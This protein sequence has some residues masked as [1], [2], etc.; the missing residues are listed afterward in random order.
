MAAHQKH[1][2]SF[3][4]QFLQAEQ[5]GRTIVDIC[6][7]FNISRKTYY[8]WKNL[9]EKNN[10]V[11]NR[12]RGRKK[13][14]DPRIEKIVIDLIKLNPGWSVDKLYLFLMENNNN[15]Q[16]VSRHW[17]Q[18]L[19]Q[20]NKLS[21]LESR[22]KYS[23]MH[24]PQ[25]APAQ[26]VPAVE[27]IPAIEQ[28]AV[29][30]AGDASPPRIT[31]SLNLSFDTIPSFAASLFN[32]Q[33]VTWL[34][35]SDKL[36]LSGT[37]IVSI[38]NALLVSRIIGA[39]AA[40]EEISGKI[41]TF[42]SAIALFC[43][44]FFF[45]YS[46]KYYITIAA[47]IL[48]SRSD[49]KKS[50]SPGLVE[51]VTG[52]IPYIG[53]V[54][55]SLYKRVTRTELDPVSLHKEVQN[56]ELT[57]YP[58]F[59]VQIPLYNEKKVA[60]RVTAAAAAMDYPNFEVLVCDDSTDETTQLL[61]DKWNGH[62]KVKILHR[63]IRS[64]FKG[65][66]LDNALKYMDERTEY[67][68]IFDADFVPY[69]DTLQLFAKYFKVIG[70]HERNNTI[71]PSMA[72]ANQV[73]KDIQAAQ[74]QGKTVAVQGYQ[75]HVLNKSENWITRAVRSEFAGS[76]I[77][78]RSGGQ[79]FGL[80]KQIAGSVYA[81]N[82]KVLR[83]VGWGT[84][85]TEDFQLTLKLYQQGYKVAYTPYIQAPSECVS[86]LKRLIR[87]R[88]R[89]AEGHSFNIKKQLFA[90]LKSPGMTPKE[91]WEAI[92]LTPY[93]LQAFIFILGSI[94]WIIAETVLRVQLP[95]WT[96]A[97]GWS[98]VLT[99]LFS[100]PLMNTVGLFL[101]EGEERDYL[102]IFSFITLC[103]ILAPFIGF[104]AVKGFLEKEEGPWFRTPKSGHITDKVNR[105]KEGKRETIIKY[106][107]WIKPAIN[108]FNSIIPERASSAVSPYLAYETAGNDFNNPRQERNRSILKKRLTHLSIL[109][110]LS[111]TVLANIA[112]TT[113]P[114]SFAVA[115]TQYART[116]DAD[117]LTNTATAA[118]K[119]LSS[120]IGASTTSRTLD[121]TNTTFYILT[122]NMNKNWTNDTEINDSNTTGERR[123]V[124]ISTDSS[125]NTVAVW[126]DSRTTLTTV[127][128]RFDNTQ[129]A[130][131]TGRYAA[132]VIPLLD[133]R[134]LIAGGQTS[135]PTNLSSGEIFDPITG[136]FSAIATNMANARY[137]GNGTVLNDGRAFLVSG[138]SG[139]TA[140][141]TTSFF[142]PNTNSFSA[143]P[144]MTTARY[145]APIEKLN[146][147]KIL[148][149]G[150][151]TAVDAV[152]GT[153]SSGYLS[154]AELYD[155]A[156]NTW[157]LTGTMKDM[158]SFHQS[159]LLPNGEVL[160][161]GGS[162]GSALST[163]E[164]YNTVTGTWR[165]GAN[166]VT[167]RLFPALA[168]VTDTKAMVVGGMTTSTDLSSTEL[169]DYVANTWNSNGNIN[170]ANVGGFMRNGFMK[171]ANGKFLLAGS[172]KSTDAGNP[173]ST[174]LLY[175][176]SINT[177]ST[178]SNNISTPKS[179]F[180]MALL[181]NGDI[182]LPGGVTTGTS[183]T[184]NS[185]LYT[186]VTYDIYAQK[187]DK[188]GAKLWNSGSDIRVNSDDG[189]RLSASGPPN[190]NHLFPT[191]GIDGS[192]NAVVAWA[193]QR[194][195]VYSPSIW[196][197]KLQSSDGSKL[198]PSGTKNAF[199]ATGNNLSQIRGGD[200]TSATTM[201]TPDGRLFVVGSELTGAPRTSS[202]IY[203][204]TTNTFSAGPN[205]AVQRSNATTVPLMNGK[206]LVI[207]GNTGT[208]ASTAAQLY[209]PVTGTYATTT[210]G[211]IHVRSGPQATLLK[212]GKVFI[213]GTNLDPGAGQSVSEIYDPVT[214]TFALGPTL[215]FNRR[216]HAQALLPNGKVIIIGGIGSGAAP[217][218][219]EI[220]DPVTNTITISNARNANKARSTAVTLNNGKILHIGSASSRSIAELYDPLTDDFTDAGW[221]SKFIDRVHD[222]AVVLPNGKVLLAGGTDSAGT[223]DFSSTEIYDPATNTWSPGP[224]M[225][226]S[227]RQANLT[228]IPK[229]H[230]VLTYGGSTTSVTSSSA[231][232]YTPVTDMQVSQFDYKTN[233]MLQG[234][235]AGNITGIFY[236]KPKI[237][238]NSTGDAVIAWQENKDTR[239]AFQGLSHAFDANARYD[240]GRNPA[241][242][243]NCQNGTGC[244]AI[245][246][247]ISPPI[248]IAAQRICNQASCTDA[249][250]T[251]GERTW[252]DTQSLYNQN[253]PEN[254]YVSNVRNA[255]NV[256]VTSDGTST[257]LI[258]E[259]DSGLSQDLS[260]T[261]K[262]D[263]KT[264]K[265]YMQKLDAD[266][267]TLWT[268]GWTA[269][270]GGM[271]SN[272]RTQTTTLL[273]NGS[274]LLAGGQNGSALSSAEVHN[275]ETLT[276]VAATNNM[277][278]ARINHSAT[279]LNNGKVLISGGGTTSSTSS[280]TADLFTPSGTSGSFAATVGAMKVSRADHS[281]VLL[282]N[283]KVLLAGGRNATT[284]TSTAE[285]YDS[286]TAVAAS[287]FTSTTNNMTAGI[288]YGHRASLLPNGNVVVAGGT[289]GTGPLSSAEIYDDASGTWGNASIMVQ[290]RSQ[291]SLTLLPN[292]KILAVGGCI[293]GN[294]T[295]GAA[296][297]TSTAELF[298][299][300][301]NAWTSTG[302]LVIGVRSEHS[303]SLLPSGKVVIY[304]GTTDGTTFLST[305]EIYDPATGTFTAGSTAQ[306]GRRDHDAI[307]LTNGKVM[308]FDGWNGTTTFSSSELLSFDQQISTG[309]ATQSQN[310]DVVK[311]SSGNLQ[312]VWQ[313]WRAEGLGLGS[314]GGS[315][316]VMTQEINNPASG[317][318]TKQYPSGTVN[319]WATSANMSTARRDHASVLLPNGKII[320]GGGID[321][322]SGQLSSTEIYDPQTGTWSAGATMV[323]HHAGFAM[324]TL[325]SGKVIAFAG[326][327]AGS[328]K[329][330]IYDPAAN[331]WTAPTSANLVLA[332]S[333]YAVT[334]LNDGKIMLVGGQDGNSTAMRTTSELF[335]P[336]TQTWTNTT[337]GLTTG[338]QYFSVT[339]TN[340]GKV[341]AIGGCT[342]A[343]TC[344][345]AN[346]VNTIEVY[347]PSTSTWSSVSAT[348]G[349]ARF[350]HNATLLP[351]GKILINGGQ[352]SSGTNLSS[353]EIFDPNSLT[354]TT[355]ATAPFSS[356]RGNNPLP[357]S[358]TLSNGKVFLTRGIASNSTAT[359]TM[360]YD[361]TSDTWASTTG[362]LSKGYYAASI[363]GMKNGK[364]LIMGGSDSSTNYYSSSEL[365]TPELSEQPVSSD[366]SSVNYDQTEPKI[367][368][369]TANA[370]SYVAWND[371]RV[372][373]PSDTTGEMNIYMQKLDGGGNPVW[374][375]G[376]GENGSYNVRDT[377]VDT[378]RGS[379]NTSVQ[380]GVAIAKSVFTNTATDVPIQLAWTD[381]RDGTPTSS[382][383][384]QSYNTRNYSMS[385]TTWTAYYYITGS[386]TNANSIKVQVG[387]TE[388]DGETVS[389]TS[390]ESTYTG[391]GTNGQKSTVFS[392][393]PPT[394]DTSLT[395]RRLILKFTRS[396][397]SMT[398]SYNGGAGVADT[399]LEVGTIVPERSLMLVLIIPAL[400]ALAL[401]HKRYRV[402]L[403]RQH[404]SKTKV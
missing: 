218:V 367:G 302:S 168:M 205:T 262:T 362:G 329:T 281:S 133:G 301:K 107:P 276:S 323:N 30:H 67:V 100:L 98:L 72:A 153:C 308:T 1:T 252:G 400:P 138:G 270:S 76:Y 278:V 78:E 243:G 280:S 347:N 71:N 139:T 156:T 402:H 199:A 145:S 134:V 242:V 179:L 57:E 127:Q 324:F 51:K 109:V 152:S 267:K 348:L 120:T 231:E 257:A 320:A 161:V 151:C 21:T 157:T 188:T 345:G 369:D 22:M 264:S 48:K 245:P 171:L 94:C 178:V 132:P 397:G 20:K 330:D 342:N 17:I 26:E 31:P 209:D 101:E 265:I 167:A 39:V 399:R 131:G 187:Y 340:D 284:A 175:D 279:L 15:Q 274:V 7:E 351:N 333:E 6:N 271:V 110:V 204:P 193:E 128:N 358:A 325:S 396:T 261:S 148:I 54:I 99:N 349:T 337:G 234:A 207:G 53:P 350:R 37:V 334:A 182:L 163:S 112:Q 357:Y 185:N 241:V 165:A 12:Q 263:P 50:T 332:H 18:L 86:T 166:M 359:Q 282:R 2:S 116:T 95:F 147:G 146:N 285:L 387:T 219:P 42:L 80:L 379:L 88:Q 118:R 248:Q 235:V 96:A 244:G 97:L 295:A 382:I 388:S 296:N 289:N 336:A 108:V 113:V 174:A 314:G 186:P 32:K 60:N 191:V 106:L 49:K 210:G 372:T 398:I 44:I 41:G 29:L 211:N 339:K 303:A 87:Q 159:T 229:S 25:P 328:N 181:P 217:T 8:K 55:Q 238:I 197:Q 403:I 126:E 83:E 288:R 254:I 203:N 375:N 346:I 129:G 150:G 223:T 208:L 360:L 79:V 111:I 3:R 164:I 343:S 89:W 297:R 239:T 144:N 259:S 69:P 233:I 68:V 393:L 122:D 5:E 249:G 300:L 82:A 117:N 215:N 176:P 322:S 170:S 14:V 404:N 341:Y 91:K 183:S 335:D 158:R 311:D 268:G 224:N 85:I 38:I 56:T 190:Y 93:Y 232:V 10:S 251:S 172:Y 378:T 250:T 258:Y 298:D 307:A 75:W 16:L 365:Y 237:T 318:V 246:S 395:H 45:L 287:A 213:T 220:Y 66:A 312:A 114:Q 103:Y 368:A 266:G 58:F 200:N 385:S 338:R 192:G 389:Y 62:D 247:I 123:N 19:L 184:T 35:K 194:D 59:S 371:D 154:T 384:G 373:S 356:S 272:R 331:T 293:A 361:P 326:Y 273:P 64:G 214:N 206:I 28:Q 227:R 104:A 366:D 40:A 283:G 195:G 73:V 253:M 33:T 344:S 212:N 102:G 27:V 390:A 11:E 143:G 392:N 155:P 180:N 222:A 63:T 230:K 275:P 221:T 291:F 90:M 125:G 255:R 363:I 4:A 77:I 140:Y 74:Y 310:P 374:P 309:N 313:A 177:W 294:C 299:P 92:Y 315:W 24:S 136:T 292:G 377:R 160:V 376:L 36:Y 52:E 65:A 198:W 260:T 240:Y 169:Y 370:Y 277:P 130:M 225:A 380:T 189:N 149:M 162:N 306:T 319:S 236:K 391:D 9:F 228:F 354:I 124:A 286:T 386:P 316:K 226:A 394:N 23:Y 256:N 70:D 13:T 105:T 202:D 141:S 304:G 355:A 401:G 381:T 352:N 47:V 353:S 46:I 119:V 137:M 84:S 61:Y 115:S 305:T 290:K 196:A 142:D 216:L 321:Q 34:F 135:G 81:I 269:P 43:G 201:V 173:S 364:V 327:N 383:Y 317:A 121:A